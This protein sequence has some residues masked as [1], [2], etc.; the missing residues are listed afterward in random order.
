M[1]S[2]STEV[3]VGYAGFGASAGYGKSTGKTDSSGTTDKN[4]EITQSSKKS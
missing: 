1:N 4:K 2:L 3:S